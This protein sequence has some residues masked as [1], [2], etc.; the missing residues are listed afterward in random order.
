M[1][2]YCRRELITYS[3]FFGF[4]EPQILEVRENG[5]T[6]KIVILLARTRSY[7]ISVKHISS[8]VLVNCFGTRA[9]KMTFLSATKRRY[10]I[11]RVRHVE[12]PSVRFSDHSLLSSSSGYQAVDELINR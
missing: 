2:F 11:T 7:I 9:P 6:L 8:S 4:G 3:Y 12:R 1:E 5:K 10:T